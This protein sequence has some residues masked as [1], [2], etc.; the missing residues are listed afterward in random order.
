MYGLEDTQDNI[1]PVLKKDVKPAI[2]IIIIRMNVDELY[3]IMYYG[4]FKLNIT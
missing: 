3:T 4:H 1:Y 2:I